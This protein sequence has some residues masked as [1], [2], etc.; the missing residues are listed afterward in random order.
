M[1]DPAADRST[2]ARIKIVSGETDFKQGRHPA[3][4]S[5]PSPRSAWRTC[6][7]KSYADKDVNGVLSPVRRHLP[8][9]HRGPEGQS[10]TAAATRPCPVVTGQDAELQSVKSILAGRAV[11]DHLQGHPRA[12]QGHRRDDRGR[13]SAAKTVDGQRH[14]DLRQRRQ[15]RPDLRCSQPVSVDKANVTEVLVDARLLHRG[16][17]RRLTSQLPQHCGWRGGRCARS[18]HHAPPGRAAPIIHG[19]AREGY[20]RMSDTILVD[21][22]HHQGVPRG[23]GAVGREPRRCKRGEIH[24]SAGRTAPASRP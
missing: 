1:S 23:Q 15:G 17:D 14:Q 20:R 8:R 2:T 19:P 12:G 10:A 18:P 7:T 24:A 5:P 21:A 22:R 6:C 11:L 16:R 4:G 3:L 9:H 13:S